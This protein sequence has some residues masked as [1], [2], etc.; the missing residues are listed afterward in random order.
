MAPLLTALDLA[1]LLDDANTVVLDASW[2]MPA[3]ARDPHT[4]FLNAHIR[5]AERFDFDDVIKHTSILQSK[6]ISIYKIP[7]SFSHAVQ[8]RWINFTQIF[9][10]VPVTPVPRF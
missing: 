1:Q 5:G 6:K 7:D 4:D 8:L 10:G 9:P 2:Y 3:A